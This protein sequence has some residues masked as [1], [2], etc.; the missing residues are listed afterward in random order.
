MKRK[1]GKRLDGTTHEIKSGYVVEVPQL[2]WCDFCADGL[3]LAEYDFKTNMGPWANGCEKHW[4]QHRARPET[5]L[6]IGQLLVTDVEVI[7][8]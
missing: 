4:K 8:S 7:V 1:M 2:P 5:G 6:G 3:T